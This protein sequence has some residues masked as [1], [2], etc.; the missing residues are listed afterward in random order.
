M[1]LIYTRYGPIDSNPHR[2]D[3]R[4]LESAYRLHENQS[5]LR[6]LLRFAE[7]FRGVKNHPFEPGFDL[8]MR[9]ARLK[10]PLKWRKP[11]S[12]F[13]N[14]MSD[15]FHKDVPRAYIDQVFD[16]MEKAHWHTFHV[17]TKRSSLLRDYINQRYA[18]RTAAAHI[19]L[20]VSVENRQQVSRIRHL[21]EAAATTR[22]LSI[23][24][25]LGPLGQLDLTG[26]HWVILGGESG[27]RCR[28]LDEAWAI[29]IRD[30]CVAAGIPFFFKQWGGFRPKTGGRLL[31]GREWS[32][33][34]PHHPLAA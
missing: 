16:T 32:Q 13:V 30:Q 27:P 9:P 24:P 17:L 28:A 31:Q 25:L 6:Q 10:Q 19:W 12:I 7:R 4:H 1:R 21:Q 20:G 29:D 34:P 33:F 26:I 5:R 11:L 14:S 8:T 22:F 3:E 18:G 2:V 23:E 15:L